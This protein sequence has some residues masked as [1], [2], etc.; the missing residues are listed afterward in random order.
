MINVWRKCAFSHYI[1][2]CAPLVTRNAQYW[3][4]EE[5][6]HLSGCYSYSECDTNCGRSLT[7]P[8][9]P[10]LSFPQLQQVFKWLSHPS[11]CPSFFRTFASL[12]IT[13]T[14][15]KP[16]SRNVPP[17]FPNLSPAKMAR[18]RAISGAVL[19]ISR[20]SLS[21]SIFPNL[22][23]HKG[24]PMSLISPLGRRGERFF[25]GS[26]SR[27]RF[28]RSNTP[29]RPK[30]MD[31]LTLSHRHAL[32]LS[33]F[34]DYRQESTRKILWEWE[35]RGNRETTRWTFRARM[36]KEIESARSESISTDPNSRIRHQIPNH[37][38]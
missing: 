29:K 4:L 8:S 34:S 37:G 26:A 24:V 35:I 1:A 31:G 20:T 18:V 2:R 15:E 19:L 28:I 21:L 14:K 10:V 16:R 12:K 30:G 3:G 9:I 38:R 33:R 6:T 25:I 36:S 11:L 23:R 7:T 13:W 5:S 22:Y 32:S 17:D 27:R